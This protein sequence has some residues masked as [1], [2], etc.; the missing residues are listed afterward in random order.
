MASRP[1]RAF[2]EWRG[3]SVRGQGHALGGEAGFDDGGQ[4]LGNRVKRGRIGF[5]T[6]PAGCSRHRMA[7]S[8]AR[9]RVAAAEEPS[10]GYVLHAAQRPPERGGVVVAFRDGGLNRGGAHAWPGRI[11]PVDRRGGGLHG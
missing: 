3:G 6:T 8:K 5:L 1:C 7:A 9:L 11:V 2:A 10:V 4:F